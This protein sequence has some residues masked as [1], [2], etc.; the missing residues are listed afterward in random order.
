MDATRTLKTQLRTWLKEPQVENP[1]RRVWRDWVVLVVPLIGLVLELALRGDI[2]EPPFDAIHGRPFAVPF[3]ALLAVALLWRRTHP[4]E[5]G[6]FG[7]GGVLIFDTIGTLSGY[8]ELNLNSAVILLFAVYSAFRWGSGKA[9]YVIGVL[10][11]LAATMANVVDYTTV[12]D[13]VGGYI[14]IVMAGAVGLAIRYRGQ[15]RQQAREQARVNERERIARELHDTVAHH[16]SAIAIQAQAGR[17]VAEQGSIEGASKALGVIEEEA[18]RTL[19][20]M[21][22]IVAVLRDRSGAGTAGTAANG[23]GALDLRPQHGIADLD[24]LSAPDGSPVVTVSVDDGARNGNVSP[25]VG[26]A[27]YRIAQ[28]SITNA[29]RHA[30]GATLVEV[31]VELRAAEVRLT[32]TD[33]G[34][35]SG[36]SSLPGFGLI[37]MA[38][39][40]TLLDGSLDAG[41]A[42][43]G[44]TGTTGTT[45]NTGWRVEAVLPRQAGLGHD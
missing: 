22:A 21:R 31:R 38:E 24:S 29:R 14:I 25:S 44:S 23:A 2:H 6:L 40:A 37:G 11:I 16:V 42:G 7:M 19:D 9:M 34:N 26:A 28:E 36:A 27:L 41:P 20:E 35:S 1:P 12:S 43:T 13:V 30:H 3:V 17:F 10:G 8:G 5:V 33:N 39:R 32:V 45:G 4:F 15:S 18:S